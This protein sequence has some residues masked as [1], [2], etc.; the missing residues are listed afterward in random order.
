MKTCARFQILKKRGEVKGVV[1]N[2][3]KYS[4]QLRH[5]HNNDEDDDVIDVHDIRK[6]LNLKVI[7]CWHLSM[8][9]VSVKHFGIIIES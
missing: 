1:M 4:L 9:S 6:Q 3:D 2:E 7:Q 8:K 5:H